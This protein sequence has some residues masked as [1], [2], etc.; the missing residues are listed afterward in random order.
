MLAV[1]VAAAASAQPKRVLYLT[2]S[3][4]FRHDSIITSI[5]VMRSL[6]P[7]ALEVTQTENLAAISAEGLRNFDA[8]FFF[9]SGE[10]ALSS[11]QKSALLDF[12][13]SGKGFGGVHSATDTLYTWP[14]YHELIGATFDGHPWAQRIRIDIE[15]PTH[16]LVS[17]LA[18]GFEIADEIYQHRDFSRSRVRVLMTLDTTSVDMNLPGINRTDLDFALAWAQTY[19]QGRSFYTAL[20][21]V[22]ETWLDPRFQQM[23]RNALLWLTGQIEAP[24]A[25][26]PIG[27]PRIAGD[28]SSPAVGN[29]ATLMP[30]AI[31]PG[32]LF[33]IYGE[34]LT[35]GSESAAVTS[36]P[37]RK[38]GGTVVLLNGD[39]IPLLYASPRQINALAPSTLQGSVCSQPGGQCVQLHVNAPGLAASTSAT[40]GLADRTPGIFVTTNNLDGTATIWATGLGAVRPAGNL[41][42]T[43][44]RP[45][46]EINGTAA[47]VLFSGL[48][49]GWIGLYQINVR[50]PAGVTEPLD[51]R[52]LE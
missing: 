25:P 52:L 16:P 47:S 17:H 18:P 40:V 11:D 2:H 46:V 35:I 10:L 1:S 26:R 24:A 49:P 38:L 5:G 22:D 7:D 36:Q 33:S 50:L 41:F 3:A 4:G 13:R 29:A 39:P 28:E 31:S 12:V 43:V 42:E 21:H 14:E 32:T 27:Q 48:A 45:R 37:P 6:S 19:G 15:E 44:W 23:L 20:G 51:V 8:V 30:R 34:N 9:T